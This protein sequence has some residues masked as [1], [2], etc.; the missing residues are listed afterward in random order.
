[1]R[2]IYDYSIKEYSLGND[3]FEII[4][5]DRRK[6]NYA[7]DDVDNV[8]GLTSDPFKIKFYKGDCLILHFS[9]IEFISAFLKGWERYLENFG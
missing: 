9:E 2:W 6:K 3:G 8:S 5:M 4:F 1:M 7:W